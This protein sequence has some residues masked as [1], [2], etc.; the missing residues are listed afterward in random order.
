MQGWAQPLSIRAKPGS[1]QEPTLVGSGP[2]SACA[3]KGAP[4]CMGVAWPK[5]SNSG[6]GI[7]SSPPGVERRRDARVGAASL[8]PGEAL[9]GPGA[10]SGAVWPDSAC[11]VEGAPGGKGG[12]QAKAERLRGGCSPSCRAKPG[13]GWEPVPVGSCPDSADSA[14][15][16]GG[17]QGCMGVAG[18]KPSD[19][20]EGAAS[21]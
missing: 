20:G 19:A 1:G 10:H 8:H 17:P 3:A 11:A 21:L 5:P 16:A 15:A 13:S 12:R 14:C 6:E 18:P 9:I 2:G 7:A 4:D